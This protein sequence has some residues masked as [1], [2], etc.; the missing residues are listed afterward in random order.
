MAFAIPSL[1][2]RNFKK[3]NKLIC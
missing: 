3:Q 2:F 1:C